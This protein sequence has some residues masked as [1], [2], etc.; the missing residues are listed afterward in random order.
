MTTFLVIDAGSTKFEWAFVNFNGE[1]I[2]TGKTRGFNAIL[3]TQ[4]SIESTLRQAID[5]EIVIAPSEVFYYGAGCA[6]PRICDIISHAIKH[7]WKDI[8]VSVS[9]DLLGAG[10]A[11]FGEKKGIACI[12]GTGSNSCIYD[13][14]YIKQQ[15][16]SMGYILGDEGSGAALGKRLLRDIYKRQLSEDIIECF[17][18][19]YDLDLYYI[20]ERT[21]N[22][23]CANSFLASFAPFLKEN[24]WR[25]EIYSLV[26]SEL[27]E[28]IKR[29][30]AMYKGANSL[31]VGFVG[32][33]ANN[34]DKV[35]REAAAAFGYPVTLIIQNPL[36]G[37][38]EYHLQNHNT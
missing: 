21:Y 15:I 16:P 11:L 1:I 22:M 35:L 29:N 34:F 26:L 28:F 23:P 7:T 6:T 32:S 27:G 9:S 30:V 10:R 31:P 14:G 36:N 19:T 18:K 37:L 2:A 24:L 3:E 33:I 5:T 25:P 38:I 12:L 20:L 13:Q 4:E 8:S 17:N